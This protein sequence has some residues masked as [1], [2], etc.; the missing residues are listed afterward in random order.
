MAGQGRATA[1]S[2]CRSPSG[3]QISCE[4]HRHRWLRDFSQVHN[5]NN[6]NV[7]QAWLLGAVI[8]VVQ[9]SI[10]AQV[11]IAFL[12]SLSCSSLRL[13]TIRQ[14]MHQHTHTHTQNESSVPKASDAGQKRPG[15]LRKLQAAGIS[16]IPAVAA[17]CG[18]SDSYSLHIMPPGSSMNGTAAKR[19]ESNKTDVR[20]C[21]C[22][23]HNQGMDCKDGKSTKHLGINPGN[24]NC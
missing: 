1:G 9:V 16:P 2:G 20:K 23:K 3:R 22:Y 4:Q 5:K 17:G 18:T 15:G 7:H 19:P 10:L 12:H 6:N 14:R 24:S 13:Q 11:E 8:S 21:Y